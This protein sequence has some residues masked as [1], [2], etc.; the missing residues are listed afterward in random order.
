MAVTTIAVSHHRKPSAPSSPAAWK[1]NLAIQKRTEQ[2]D[3]SK[4]VLLS[5]T[6]DGQPIWT[7]AGSSKMSAGEKEE[8]SANLAAHRRLAAIKQAAQ[9]VKTAA[10]TF[11]ECVVMNTAP[12]PVVASYNGDL[13]DAGATF[14]D[15]FLHSGFT[16]KQDELTSIVLHGGKE[17][18][19]FDAK[20]DPLLRADVIQML[21]FE[22]SLAASMEAQSG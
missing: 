5:H 22:R 8:L 1:A 2:L 9:E 16:F 12:A 14:K 20:V 4:E 17:V 11:L 7:T 21:A 10:A 13:D 18:A 15:W 6:P 19:R 3:N